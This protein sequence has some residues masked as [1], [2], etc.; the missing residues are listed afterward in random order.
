MTNEDSWGDEKIKRSR[1]PKLR[2]VSEGCSVTE[3]APRMDRVGVLPVEEL[4]L[5][6]DWKN[7]VT[8]KTSEGHTY[9]LHH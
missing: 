1:G 7:R 5:W 3:H 2:P 6:R 4:F 9:F 8:E